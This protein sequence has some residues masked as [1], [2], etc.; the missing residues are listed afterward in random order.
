MFKSFFLVLTKFSFWRRDWPLGYHSMGFRHFP[1]A[2]WFPKILSH[3]SFGNWWGNS[4]IPCLLVI[5]AHRFTCGKKKKKK[6]KLVKKSQ[7]IMKMIVDITITDSYKQAIWWKRLFTFSHCEDSS[8]R[9]EQPS[10]SCL[11]FNL[12]IHSIIYL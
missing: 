4:Y 6:K 5:I 12:F 1:D 9:Q 2:S 3:K 7:N 10:K 11:F 8:N